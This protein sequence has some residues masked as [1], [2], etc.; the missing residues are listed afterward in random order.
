MVALLGWLIYASSGSEMNRFLQDIGIP[1]AAVRN[2]CVGAAEV[3]VFLLGWCLV[4]GLSW[5]FS[6]VTFMEE[7]ESMDAALAL[8]HPRWPETRPTWIKY[9]D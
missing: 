2:P 4:G 1:A 9:Y 8:F 7:G 6:A 3:S 5:P